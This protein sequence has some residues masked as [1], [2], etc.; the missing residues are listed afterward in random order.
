M[1]LEIKDLLVLL[2]MICVIIVAA[3]FITRTG[4]FSEALDRQLSFRSRVYLILFFGI[5]SIYGTLSGVEVLGAPINVRD[6]GPMVAGIFCGPVVG[7]GAGLIGGAFRMG[8]GGF[9]AFS[10]SISTV[11]AGVLGGAIYYLQRGRPVTIRTAVGF[12]AGMEMLHMVLVL[13]LSQ[14]FDQAWDLVSRVG[15]PMIFANAVGMFV[16]AK[17]ITN[18]LAERRTKAE[19]DSYHDELQRKKAELQIAADIQQTFLPK[20]I[21]PLKGFD[22]FAVSCPAREVGGDFYDAIRLREDNTGLVIA[23]VSGKSVSAAMYMALSRTIIRAMASWHPEVS[24]A[25]ADANT[26]IEEQSDS[27]MFVTL[28]YG[29]LDEKSRTL[30]YANAGHNPP[31]M[32]RAGSSD[33]SRLMPTG[34]ALGAASEQEYG[35]DRIDVLQG[36]L[37]VLYTD[38]VTEAI[39][40]RN[41]EFGEAR[42]METILMVRALSSQEIIR[43][44]RDAVRE[45]AEEEPQF[46]DITLMVLK[47]V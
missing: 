27:G 33:F 39:N 15:L 31:L 7:L 41:E 3:Y 23:D 12:A 42:L 1:I 25:L 11:L 28:F 5:L 2:Q 45:H 38:G 43:E 8:L 35:E 18:L 32:L 21:P 29:V 4:I 47:G 16:F 9:T 14:P 24:L 17:L 37:L 46:D 34:V 13:I 20:S 22:L 36:D 44:I 26:M 40:A 19:R 30:T 10:C 6:L